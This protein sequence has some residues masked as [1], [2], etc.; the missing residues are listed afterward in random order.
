MSSNP[1][2]SGSHLDELGRRGTVV[3]RAAGDVLV[4][5][6]ERGDHVFVVLSGTA[7]ID[8]DGREVLPP[9]S[10]GECIGELAVLDS[11]P[12]AMTVTAATPMRLLSFEAPRFQAALEEVPGLRDHVTR[13]LTRRLRS[14]HS[15]WAELAVDA[16][17]L[18]DALVTLQGSEEPASRA[19]AVRQAAALVRR[20]AE[21]HATA[22]ARLSVLTPAEARVAELV[23]DGL[24]NAAIA[25]RLF[26]SEH[27]VA[28]HLKHAFTKLGCGSRVDL[29][30]TVLRSR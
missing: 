27:T 15:S 4:R 11:A 14:A 5:Q 10:A 12:R 20:V 28:S 26:L 2:L 13:A 1:A 7:R 30:A 23:A 8:L 16:D 29:A 18:L 22:S 3:D 21:E 17:V 25:E 24:S 9:V 6:G 19:E